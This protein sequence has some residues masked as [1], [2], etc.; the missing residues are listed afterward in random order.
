MY[1]LLLHVTY[2]PFEPGF[3]ELV[4][5][6][7]TRVSGLETRVWVLEFWVSGLGTQVW[8]LEIVVS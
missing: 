1:K 6:L 2:K 5:G 4:S 7:G 8:S 3:L